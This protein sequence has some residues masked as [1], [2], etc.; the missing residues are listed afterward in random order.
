MELRE[1]MFQAQ[2]QILLSK[3]NEVSNSQ[4]SG[5]EEVE[6]NTKLSS[7]TQ[8]QQKIEDKKL[9]YNEEDDDIRPQKSMLE[10]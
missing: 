6:H 4:D 7:K 3:I 8:Q 2:Q 1:Q 5:K 9:D 10:I